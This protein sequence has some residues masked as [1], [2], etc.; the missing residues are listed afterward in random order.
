M[1]RIAVPLSRA[2]SPTRSISGA[3]PIGVG[4][5]GRLVVIVDDDLNILEAMRLLIGGWGAEVLVARSADEA[6]EGLNLRARPPDVILADHSLAAAAT[7]VDAIE[8]IRKACDAP[9]PALIITG[10]T[11]PEVIERIRNS[12]YPHLIKPIPP[13][14]LRAALQSALRAG[15]GS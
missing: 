5:S 6:L 1:F 8:V 11:D 3:L 15:Q 12:G 14:R 13:A 4:L 7:G 10:E 2:A 9:V